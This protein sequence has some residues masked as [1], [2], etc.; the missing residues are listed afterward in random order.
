MQLQVTWP[1]ERFLTYIVIW[2]TKSKRRR[3]GHIAH[4]GEKRGAN[5]FW[6]NNLG[7]GDHLEDQGL[8]VRIILN[9]SSGSYRSFT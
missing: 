4:M 5:G 2:V 9:G 3:V 7:D 8:H 6:W 1:S